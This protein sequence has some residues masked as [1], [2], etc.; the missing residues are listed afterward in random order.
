MKLSVAIISFNEE[1]N[2][3]RTLEA[4]RPLADEIVVLDSFSTDNTVSIAREL[5]AQV[6]QAPW[7][8]YIEQ[9][10]A[11]LEKCNGEWVL[12]LDCDEVV[13]P[14]LAESIRQAMN[15]PQKYAGFTLNRRTFYL[16]RLLC[17]AWQPDRKLRLVRRAAS[18]K[19]T[20]DNPHD[21]LCVD[22]PLGHCHGD[23]VHYSYRDFSA[24]MAQTQRFAKQIAES[25]YAKGRKAGYA[26][27]L[28]RPPFVFFKRFILQRA[29]L[30]GVPG[31]LAAVSSAAYSY[32]KYAFLW[33]LWAEKDA[34]KT[35]NIPKK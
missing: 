30:D 7:P 16:G 13:S 25:Y 34:D 9:K 28:F 35:K 12:S 22:G 27:L 29:C 1:A 4:I 23:L 6:F 32:M 11:C 15:N 14:E 10:N 31:L 26:D 17:H 33:E 19:W 18:P 20:G 5:G 24:H 3:R 8:G 21:R 2:I